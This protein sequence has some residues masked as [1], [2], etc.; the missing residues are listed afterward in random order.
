MTGKGRRSAYVIHGDVFFFVYCNCWI[1]EEPCRGRMM[2]EVD[3]ENQI[4]ECPNCGTRAEKVGR[5]EVVI[6][7]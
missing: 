1:N 7:D 2:N 5:I 4:F 3:E 6:S